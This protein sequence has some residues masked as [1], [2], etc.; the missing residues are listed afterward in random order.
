MQTGWFICFAPLQ[1]CCPCSLTCVKLHLPC[2]RCQCSC[3]SQCRCK[4]RH[5]LCRQD[6]RD[7]DM[8]FRENHCSLRIPLQTS[9]I[10][11][12]Q[13][14]YC[15]YQVY[16]CNCLCGLQI[17]NLCPCSPL[18]WFRY[19]QVPHKS[20]SEVSQ[21]SPDA[22]ERLRRL[23]QLLQTCWHRNLAS[24]DVKRKQEFRIQSGSSAK[25]EYI[26]TPASIALG[27]H[28]HQADILGVKAVK[29][30]GQALLT[31][32]QRSGLNRLFVTG[33]SNRNQ[34][35]VSSPKNSACPFHSSTVPK[36]P[37]PNIAGSR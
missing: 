7:I 22:A 9:L 1:L 35:V 20:E 2:R 19:T 30:R 12:R 34:G 16:D 24:N 6:C 26:R 13:W 23:L 17:S 10:V 4:T 29:Q 5:Q 27:M 18:G 14:S 8:D 3:C 21:A 11:Q 25:Q 37:K 32:D 31:S 28:Q 36:A 15:R 33:A